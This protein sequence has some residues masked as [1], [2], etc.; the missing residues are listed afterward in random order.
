MSPSLSEYLYMH[1]YTDN[2]RDDKGMKTLIPTTQICFI[3]KNKLCYQRKVK[4]NTWFLYSFEYPNP[5]YLCFLPYN[6]TVI[7]QV[8]SIPTNFHVQSSF[9]S[10]FSVRAIILFF[11]RKAEYRFT[12]M[13]WTAHY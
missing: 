5:T 9:V 6:S 12:Y 7:F 4:K 10:Y 3:L 8:N 13:D 11:L 1:L 2:A